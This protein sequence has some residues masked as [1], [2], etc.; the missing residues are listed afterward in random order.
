MAQLRHCDDVTAIN[1]TIQ[2]R[3]I[4]VQNRDGTIE[5]YDFIV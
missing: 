5:H 2:H 1:V 4:T 3:D